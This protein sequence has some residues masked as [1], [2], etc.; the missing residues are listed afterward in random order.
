MNIYGGKKKNKLRNKNGDKSVLNL[1]ISFMKRTRW[2]KYILFL[3]HS[4]LQ[5]ECFLPYSPDKK[6]KKKSKL[7]VC[8]FSL[9][10]D[11][12]PL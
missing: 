12:C 1:L 9:L 4:R 10:Y 6:K 3:L 8:L 11:I 5:M 2:N 7:C